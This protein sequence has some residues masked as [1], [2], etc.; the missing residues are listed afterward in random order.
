MTTMS[1]LFDAIKKGG[2]NEVERLL[3]DDPTLL[4]ATENKISAILWAAYN[5]KPE[6]AELFVARGRKLTF[7]EACALG[8]TAAVRAMLD[9]DPS[10]A[11]SKSPD[12]FP[13]AGL[14]IFFGH[15]ELARLLIE[16]GA[17]VN[18]HA[19]NP[20]RV[21]LVHAAAAACDHATMRLLLERGADPNARQQMDYTAL[22]GAA[23]RGDVEMAKILL[24]AGA[25]P[26][27]RGSDGATLADVANSHGHPEFSAWLQSVT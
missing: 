6:M 22:H 24:A 18:A 20:A 23:S 5:G 27:A 10:L 13:S 3:D 7:H 25:D 21:A 9:A 2:A 8:N 12:G 15:P 19:D 17:D 14:A 16:R 1:A 26:H 11:D 4:D